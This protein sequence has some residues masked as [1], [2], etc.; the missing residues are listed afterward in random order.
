MNKTMP[1]NKVELALVA[2]F[3]STDRGSH[4]GF[5]IF[6]K[7]VKES[8]AVLYSW[9]TTFE[10]PIFHQTINLGPH[11]FHERKLAISSEILDGFDDFILS[12]SP[13]VLM[14][15]SL[16]AWMAINSINRGKINLD[17]VE[18][19]Y[20]LQADIDM[21]F[22]LTNQHILKRLKNGSLKWF[23]YYNKFDSVLMASRAANKYKP[24]GMFGAMQEGIVNVRYRKPLVIMELI[25]NA[26]MHD[27]KIRSLVFD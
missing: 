19:I 6:D 16:G 22:R 4:Q 7:D 2:G 27:T 8:R 21:N 5:K 17:T 15:H 20:T 11:Y 18:E 25:H 13:R 10:R 24:A 14:C 1:Y 12:N 9:G 26:C 3:L 23:N